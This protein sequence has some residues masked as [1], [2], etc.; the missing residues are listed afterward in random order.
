MKWVALR[1][2]KGSRRQ[3]RCTPCGHRVTWAVLAQRGAKHI[4]LVESP[5]VLRTETGDN[6]VTIEIL[7]FDQIHR[8]PVKKTP[9]PA[10]S[11]TRTAPT[12]APA[13][14]SGDGV[15]ASLTKDRIAEMRRRID[16]APAPKAP[17]T[18]RLW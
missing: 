13:I 7:A 1:I 10:A 4:A 16:Q 8:C 15:Y 11:T 17:E 6:C 12:P 18:R 5:A 14:R 9:R 2:A 3:G